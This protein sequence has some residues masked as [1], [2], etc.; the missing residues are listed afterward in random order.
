[1]VSLAVEDITKWRR[2]ETH[3]HAVGAPTIWFH[4]SGLRTAVL[5][6]DGTEL[7]RAG[8]D[9]PPFL[10]LVLPGT[11]TRY[12]YGD[13]RL[14]WTMRLAAAD[15]R[16]APGATT[17]QIRYAD[18]WLDIPLHVPVRP[19]D[20]NQWQAELTAIRAAWRSPL[21]LDQ[22]TAAAG[23]ARLLLHML[24]HGAVD[25]ANAPEAQ[26]KRLIDDDET[27]ADSLREHCKRCRRTPDHLRRLFIARYGMTPGAYRQARRRTRAA[28]LLRSSDMSMTEIS[29]ALGFSYSSRFSAFCK[30]AFGVSPS[31]F[32]RHSAAA[33]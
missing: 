5:S 14:N 28:E 15:F 17:G 8:P 2:P 20:A 29:E 25:T 11:L 24:N 10:L 3:A 16:F 12:A 30:E 26:L 1:M 6:R 18:A 32:T 22:L 23:A 27:F 33:E 21:P 4:V 13:A 9:A 7:F 31:A 19:A